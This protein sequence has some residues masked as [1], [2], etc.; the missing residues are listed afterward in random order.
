MFCLP[1]SGWFALCPSYLQRV[2]GFR[3]GVMVQK[4]API[5]VDGS[6]TEL[7]ERTERALLWKKE[8]KPLNHACGGERSVSIPRQAM[9]WGEADVSARDNEEP[10]ALRAEVEEQGAGEERG[11]VKMEDVVKA[12]L[13]TAEAAKPHTRTQSCSSSVS[14]SLFCLSFW[15]LSRPHLH[16]PAASGFVWSHLY[17]LLLLQNSLV[18]FGMSF[19]LFVWSK[20]FI[21]C[22]FVL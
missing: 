8:R 3:F 17:C 22:I 11:R 7:L 20:I 13:L 1:W 12:S 4:G 10:M 16:R 21:K 2:C 5:T 15:W 6:R 19:F 14:P 9:G 18:L